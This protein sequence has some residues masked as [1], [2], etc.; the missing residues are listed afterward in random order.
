M[1]HGG[2]DEEI[3]EGD[4]GPGTMSLPH[5]RVREGIRG[6]LIGLAAASLLTVASFYVAGTHLIWG[7]SIPM[8]L[9]VLAVAQIGVHLVFFLHITTAP[10][11]TN[12][13]LALAFGV[14]IVAL[15]VGGSIWIMQHLNQNMAP[16]SQVM[17][18]QR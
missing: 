1:S 11:N 12:N 13:V 8:A 3:D 18:M 10:D 17:E 15:I 6:Y 2:H 5:V 7:P 16:M 4:L 14:L 9:V